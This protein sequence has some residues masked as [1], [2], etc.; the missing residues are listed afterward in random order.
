M[1]K[2]I[3]SIL[4]VGVL[5]ITAP[6]AQAAEDGA[7][8]AQKGGCLA[9]H[10]V[11]KKIL[12]PSYKDVAAKYKGQGAEATLAKHVKEGSAGVWGPIPM[13]ANGAK[14]SDAEYTTVV[15]WILTQ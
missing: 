6:T 4:T 1:M 10:S 9:C 13:P 3:A 15:A 8:L 5:G 11:D 2:L 12:G 14:L 7:A